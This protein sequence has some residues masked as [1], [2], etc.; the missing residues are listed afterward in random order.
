M[1]VQMELLDA[2][3]VATYTDLPTFTC[4]FRQP[5]RWTL[6]NMDASR[7]VYISFDG[8]RD[9]ALLTPNTPSAALVFEW[10]FSQP[11]WIREGTTGPD[12]LILQVICEQ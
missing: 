10:Q 1:S 2:D 3:G 11:L 6:I 4:E 7:S 12:P 5:K 8:K 9:D